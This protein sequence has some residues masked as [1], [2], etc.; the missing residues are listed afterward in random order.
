M[1]CCLLRCGGRR[2]HPE[3]QPDVV[4]PEVGSFYVWRCL[5]AKS[6]VINGAFG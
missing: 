6:G 1:I 2:S 4:A 5:G 3:L